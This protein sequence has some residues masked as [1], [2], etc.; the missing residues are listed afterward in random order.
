MAA[1]STK[2]MPVFALVANKIDLEHLKVIK[3]DRH[4]KYAQEHG[5]LTYAVSAKT[6]EGMSLCL[7][8]VAA[9]LLGLKMR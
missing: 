4:H 3:S 8:K 2:K 7:Q 1:S 5:L 6:G 9:E